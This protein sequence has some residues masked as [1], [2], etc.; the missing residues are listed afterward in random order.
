MVPNIRDALSKTIYLGGRRY[1][2]AT[3]SLRHSKYFRI[4]EKL[5]APKPLNLE[6]E[7]ALRLKYDDKSKESHKNKI[8]K[9][10][11]AKGCSMLI[12]LPYHRYS[13]CLQPDPMHTFWSGYFDVN[14]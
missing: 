11:G 13:N 5:E 10:N 12:Q 7:T 8:V 9:E 1:L 3:H 6:D 14:Y 4:V 2:Y